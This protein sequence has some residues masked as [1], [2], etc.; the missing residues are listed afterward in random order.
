MCQK[1]VNL[2]LASPHLNFIVLL[3]TEM[4]TLPGFKFC[5]EFCHGFYHCGFQIPNWS[6]KIIYLTFCCQ[7]FLYIWH[8]QKVLMSLPVKKTENLNFLW[9]NKLEYCKIKIT[10][11]YS[12]TTTHM[13]PVLWQHWRLSNMNQD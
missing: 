2:K 10:G 11:Q 9:D 5:S 8:I 13:K 6:G 1:M 3:S 12:H 4:L 7:Q